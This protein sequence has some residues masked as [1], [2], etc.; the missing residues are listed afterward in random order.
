VRTALGY[1]RINVMG[2]SY[3]TRAALVYL[4]RH[5]ETVRCAILNGV[6]PIAFRNPLY[7]ASAAQEG[8]DKIFEEVEEH[9]EYRRAFPGLKRKFHSILHR[10]EADPVEV[11][12]DHP[13]TKEK[14]TVRLTR[15]AFA[16]ALR[17][18]LYYMDTNR[19]V[20]LCLFR[21]YEGDYEPFA[22][23]GISSNR[24]LRNMICFGMLMCVTG[25][26]DIPRIDPDSIPRL[27]KGTFLGDGRVRRQMAVASIWPRGVVPLDYG[28]PV[29][30]DVPV[31][32]LSGTHDPVTPP[33]F[34]AEAAR[35]LKKSLHLVVPG[36]H[37][38]GGPVI[39]RIMGDFLSKGTVEGLDTSGIEKIRLPPLRL[40]GKKG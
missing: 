7:H 14:V 2:G 18:M 13:V 27:T 38:V 39:D 1:E 15:E 4:R 40:P 5:P 11:A 35:H 24:R 26:E 37:G 34:G 22:T 32:L 36:A 33:R 31:L 12:V 23:L 16:E 17:I 28:D 19:Q 30:A 29:R 25:S 21:A 9:S 20:P 3:G 8:L 6:A 10:L